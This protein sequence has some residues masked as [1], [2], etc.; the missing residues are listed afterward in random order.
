MSIK[1]GDVVYL[2][3]HAYS[4]LI[5]RVTAI[6][7]QRRVSLS[8]ASKVLADSEGYESF[9]ARGVDREKTQTAYVG[10]VKDVTYLEA[11]DFNHPL[12]EPKK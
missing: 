12:P 8:D 7:G 5:G 1:P 3:V 10:T 11:I 2:W 9:F 4:R 6:L